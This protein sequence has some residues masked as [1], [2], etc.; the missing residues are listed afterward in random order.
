MKKRL[1]LEQAINNNIGKDSLDECGFV[2]T[3]SIE[4]LCR[5]LPRFEKDDEEYILLCLDKNKLTSPLKYETSKL[6]V[7]FP[8]IYGFINKE[9]IVNTLPYLKNN[10]GKYIKNPEFK[11]IKDL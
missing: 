8:H 11:E 5:V 9:A 6:G 2:H 10:E 1:Y 7:L 4:H 3:T